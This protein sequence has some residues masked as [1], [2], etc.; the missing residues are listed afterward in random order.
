MAAIHVNGIFCGDR[1]I[2][3][4]AP[5]RGSGLLPDDAGRPGQVIADPRY[6]GNFNAAREN[7]KAAC[8]G[9]LAA[10]YRPPAMTTKSSVSPQKRPALFNAGFLTSRTLRIHSA[11]VRM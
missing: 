3:G 2:V 7:A 1:R 6:A 4:G 11:A 9:L 8:E 5:E 10:L